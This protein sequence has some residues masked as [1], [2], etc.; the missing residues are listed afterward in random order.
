MCVWFFFYLSCFQMSA[1][2]RPSFSD[3]VFTLESMDIE[4]EGEKPIALGKRIKL[5]IVI[6]TCAHTFCLQHHMERLNHMTATTVRD[7][8]SRSGFPLQAH[9]RAEPWIFGMSVRNVCIY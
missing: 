2:K 3:I 9:L 6:N 4:E 8:F 5:M 1:E 7:G